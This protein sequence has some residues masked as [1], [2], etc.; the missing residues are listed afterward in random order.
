[1]KKFLIF[2]MVMFGMACSAMADV[3]YLQP[4][5]G[6]TTCAMIPGAGDKDM[7]YAVYFDTGK[8]QPSDA[9]KEYFDAVRQELA[10]LNSKDI[11]YFVVVASA[12]QQG[13]IRGY[14]N[15]ALSGRRY[16]YVKSHI[17]PSGIEVVK[18]GWIAGS[19]SNKKFEPQYIDD[20]SYRGAY[21]Y[22][23]WA[24]F[25][26]D[27]QLVNGINANITK[28]QKAKEE[29]PNQ[30]SQIE[31]ILENYNNAHKLCDTA[32]KKLGASDA[33]DLANLLN[34][35]WVLVSET[36]IVGITKLTAEMTDIDLYYSNLSQV[37]DKLKVSEWRNAEGKFNTARLLSDSIAGVV[38]GTAGGLITSHLVKKNQLK[39]GFEDLN[40]SVGGQKVAGYGDDFR[41]GLQ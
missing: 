23:V 12:D 15:V 38:L 14:N 13:D 37:R 33:E 11:A 39:K 18:D 21:I 22:P 34:G 19:A 7:M 32:G 16:D 4:A 26:C 1:M 27:A 10:K 28:L 2:F 31:K 36:N 20:W 25:T 5:D 30:R 24:R 35:A 9:C 29:H 40:C 41:I 17:L 3:G 6:N 8:D